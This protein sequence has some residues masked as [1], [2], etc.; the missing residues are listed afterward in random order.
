MEK[1]DAVAFLV[2]AFNCAE[3]VRAFFKEKIYPRA[4]LPSRCSPHPRVPSAATAKLT[5]QPARRP[6]VDT[7]VTLR[8]N[9]SPTWDP[10]L[11]EDVFASSGGS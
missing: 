7:A 3:F 5:P 2:N 6:R 9:A 10:K 1:L 8:L 11:V 4:G